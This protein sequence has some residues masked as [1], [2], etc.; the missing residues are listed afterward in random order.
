LRTV[1]LSLTVQEDRE[2]EASRERGFPTAEGV[3]ILF[4]D[5]DDDDDGGSSR[6]RRRKEA[7]GGELFH[8]DAGGPYSF[9]I[10]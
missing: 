9:P 7:G 2:R 6:A 4:T 8:G 10:M 3:G 5:D 1:L